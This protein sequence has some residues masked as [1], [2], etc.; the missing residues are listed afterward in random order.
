MMISSTKYLITSISFY[1]LLNAT[2]VELLSKNLSEIDRKCVHPPSA[3]TLPRLRYNSLRKTCAFENKPNI[4][5]YN[6][7]FSEL[8]K[9]LTTKRL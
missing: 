7:L 6:T 4:T 1:P 8:Y 2:K 9:T 5:P 3:S